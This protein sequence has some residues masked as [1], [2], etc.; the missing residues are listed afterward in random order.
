MIEDLVESVTTS[1]Y[2][3]IRVFSKENVKRNLLPFSVSFGRAAAA[4]VLLL[5]RWETLVTQES[6]HGVSRKQPSLS[7]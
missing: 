3:E 1:I 2:F 4:F 7:R 6:L 5:L